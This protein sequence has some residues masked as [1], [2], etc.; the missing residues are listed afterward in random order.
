[1]IK[2]TV[3][4]VLKAANGSQTSAYSNVFTREECKTTGGRPFQNFTARKNLIS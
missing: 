4:P 2:L 3:E 1:M